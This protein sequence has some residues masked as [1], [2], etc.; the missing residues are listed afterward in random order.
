LGGQESLELKFSE[1]REPGGYQAYWR[2]LIFT[3][4]RGWAQ[5]AK[6][7]LRQGAVDTV[8]RIA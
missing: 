1:A 5:I 3:F 8:R 6:Y 2:E 7:G 4:S